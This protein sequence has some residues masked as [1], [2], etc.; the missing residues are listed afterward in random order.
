M[1]GMWIAVEWAYVVGGGKQWDTVG[2][3]YSPV[4]QDRV[5]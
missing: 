4:V 2:H 5:A 1:V 3:Y